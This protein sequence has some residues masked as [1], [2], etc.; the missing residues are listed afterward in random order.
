VKIA[1]GT[2]GERALLA[3][4][5][6]MP[7]LLAPL[8]GGRFLLPLVAPL[9]CYP[10]FLARVRERDHFAAWRFA[11]LWAALLSAGVIL[12]TS[13]WPEAA[14]R[15]IWRGEDYRREMFDWIAT[16]LGRENDWRQ[17]LPLHL[18]HLGL[19]LA[20]TWVSAGYLGLVLGA[21]LLD[22]MNYFVASYAQASGHPLAGLVVAWVPWSLLRV[23]AFVLLGS[24]FARPLIERRLWPFARWEVRLMA[25][26]AAAWLADLLLKATMAPAY[27]RFL[28]SLVSGG[29][30]S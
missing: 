28:R 18:A 17:F 5:L 4:T 12:L 27:G 6:L 14:A 9:T 19:F 22:Y 2:V 1:R 29:L 26:A 8:P 20:L 3:A 13:V 10:G 23:M 21:A 25:L 15:G 11:M 16:G 7:L 30:L 24:L